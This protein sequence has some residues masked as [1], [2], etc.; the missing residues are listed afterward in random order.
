MG[1]EWID[2]C[3]KYTFI[4]GES[5]FQI[6]FAGM[7]FDD[8]DI[9]SLNERYA[10]VN[11]DLACGLGFCAE[12]NAASTMVTDGE[13]VVRRIVCVNSEGE[14]MTPCGSCREFLLLLSPENAKTEFLVG[15]D[16]VRTM[17]IGQL[18]PLPWTA[19]KQE[20]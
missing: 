14:L 8:K 19:F 12:R 1:T 4:D 17:T 9:D 13:T 20:Q 6:N 15:L 10:G 2:R 16:P 5:G 11:L 3:H 18:M 7:N